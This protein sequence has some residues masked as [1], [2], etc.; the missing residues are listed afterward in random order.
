MVLDL[1]MNDASQAM[2]KI[3]S[4]VNTIKEQEFDI[5]EIELDTEKEE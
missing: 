5:K 4:V 3:S 1:I 2:Q